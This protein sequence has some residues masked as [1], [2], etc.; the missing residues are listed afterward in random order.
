MRK[1]SR[2]ATFLYIMI[3][4]GVVGRVSHRSLTILGNAI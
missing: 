3:V 4:V 1:K 2:I